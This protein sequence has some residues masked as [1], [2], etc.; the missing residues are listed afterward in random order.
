MQ[1]IRLKIC[2]S[3]DTWRSQTH[4]TTKKIKQAE[5]Q[6]ENLLECQYMEM[7]LMEQPKA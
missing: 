7:Q 5:N 1:R 6:I 2:L 3:A 4:G